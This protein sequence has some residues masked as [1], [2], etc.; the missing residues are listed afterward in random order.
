MILAAGL[1]C[2]IAIAEA[3]AA[4]E[5]AVPVPPRRGDMLEIPG[6]PPIPMPPGAQ[7]FGPRGQSGEAQADPKAAPRTPAPTRPA[8]KE[9]EVKKEPQVKR[10]DLNIAATRNKFLDE[11]F[12]R[13]GKSADEDEAKGIAGA[14]ER[15]WLRS[16]SDTADLLMNRAM[17][18][19]QTKDYPLATELLDKVVV[20]DPE[21]AEA[22]NKRATVKYFTDDYAGAMADIG[23]VLKLEPR[24]FGALSGMGFILQR[25]GLERRALE[26]FRKTL[27]IYPKLDDVRKI[28]DKISIEIEGRDI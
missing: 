14:I 11:L 21:W 18:A 20:L 8:T 19:F 6:L 3:W 12:Q 17:T 15:V 26:V 10:S 7:V 13:L 23:E 9:A 28:V 24:H 5:D 22:W 16:G 1:G 2:S 27:E 25:T 4:G